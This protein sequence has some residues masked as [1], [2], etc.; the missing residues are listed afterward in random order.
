M[1]HLSTV[2]RGLNHISIMHP[3]FFSILCT[4]KLA[5]FLVRF[6]DQVFGQVS[7]QDFLISTR[8]EKISF[9]CSAG[10]INIVLQFYGGKR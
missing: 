8:T 10:T 3:D 7:D 1:N 2:H 6:F 9:A 5:R 4:E